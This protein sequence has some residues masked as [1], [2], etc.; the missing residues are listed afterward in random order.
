MNQL[1]IENHNNKH[2]QNEDKIFE[3]ENITK[4]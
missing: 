3:L 1:N 2:N 4:D